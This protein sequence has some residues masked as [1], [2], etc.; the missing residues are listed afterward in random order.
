MPLADLKTLMNASSQN[1]S[2]FKGL[3]AAYGILLGGVP[4]IDGYTALITANNATNFGAGASGPTFNDENIYINTINALYQGNATAKASFDAIVAGSASIQDALTA[5]YNYIIPASARTEAGL[6]YFKS[7]ASFYAARAAELGVAGQNGTA[8]VAF[9]ALTKIGVDNDIAGLGDTINDLRAA[10]DNGSAAIPQGGTTFTPL[11]TADGTQFDADDAPGGNNAGGT[12]NLTTGSDTLTA[13]VFNGGVVVTPLG[14][15]VQTLGSDDSLTGSGTAPTLNAT[16]NSAINVSPTLKG[17]ETVNLSTT[18]TSNIDLSKSTGLKAVSFNSSVTGADLT[19]LGLDAIVDV[20]VSNTLAGTDTLFQFKPTILAGT[21]DTVKVAL[22][23]N[24]VATAAS[25]NIN[26]V[27]QG[28]GV[29][30]TLAVTVTGTNRVNSLGSDLSAG[31]GA[32]ITAT[33]GVKSYSFAGDGSIRVDTA[34][35]GATTVDGSGLTTGGMRIIADAT[36]AVAVTGGKGNDYVDFVAGL[37]NTDKYD[38]GAGRDVLAVTTAAGIGAGNQITNVEILRLDTGFTGTFNQTNITSV[39]AVVVNTAGAVT[40]TN[41]VGANAA[42]ATKGL[43]LLNS[44]AVTFAIAGAD[45]L[46]ATNDTIAITVGQTTGAGATSSALQTAAG[47]AT[48]ALDLSNIEIINFDVK[49]D[50]AGQT[51]TGTGALTAAAAT[52]VNITGGAVGE[53]FALSGGAAFGTAGTLTKIDASSFAGNLAVSGNLG[54]QVVVGGSGDDTI[55]TGGRAAFAD[56]V[57]ADVLTGGSGRDTFVFATSDAALTGANLTTAAASAADGVREL[58]AITDLNLGGNTAASAVDLINLATVGGAN[59]AGTLGAN[60]NTVAVVN[61]GAV[62]AATGAN[63]GAAV[64]ALVNGGVLDG[65]AGVVSAGL[66]SFGGETYLIM[67]E[68][69]SAADNFGAVASADLIIRVTG[70]TGTLD[71]SDFASFV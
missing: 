33:N 47:V 2:Q 64:N 3:S 46:G 1:L 57:A 45:A 15:A 69:T 25:G 62:T 32:A 12:V 66:F 37:A 52:T 70:V 10:V 21:S 55:G 44:G 54:S 30:E 42:D 60:G 53:A 65:G 63:L 43:T 5:V 14:A 29:A 34:L 35:F 50:T 36:K 26:I 58:T 22:S 9:A 28:S 39:D 20:G 48:G 59:V 61:G 68:G 31:L 17:V 24:G 23:N 27:G 38:G 4:S 6:N 16:L 56:T 19:V 51:S 13:N 11:E 8:L 71:A 49:A 41:F 18:A 40:V 7:Q 67:S